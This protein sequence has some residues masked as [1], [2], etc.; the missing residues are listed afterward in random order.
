LI[1]EKFD[2]VVVRKEKLDVEGNYNKAEFKMS[3]VA[4]FTLRTMQN[5]YNLC[6]EYEFTNNGY[7]KPAYLKIRKAKMLQLVNN[8]DTD[9]V[10]F[11]RGYRDLD[12]G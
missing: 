1:R 12:L 9:V 7:Q 2:R 8:W 5:I 6:V 11:Y 4:E 3:E 10:D